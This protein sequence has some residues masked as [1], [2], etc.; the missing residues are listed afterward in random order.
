VKNRVSQTGEIQGSGDGVSCNSLRGPLVGF[1]KFMKNPALNVINP[2][3]IREFKTRMSLYTLG[4]ILNGKNVEHN[5]NKK[6]KKKQA[7]CKLQKNEFDLLYKK[8][9]P[10]RK[11]S[12]YF[13]TAR[14]RAVVRVYCNWSG[15]RV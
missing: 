11:E 8:F 14:L 3:E 6:E 5:K 7:S 4:D 9:G 1:D 10:N 12:G 15:I 13:H 2:Y